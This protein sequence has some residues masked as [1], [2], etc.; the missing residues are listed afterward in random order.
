MSFDLAFWYEEVPSTVD[1][2]VRIY[3]RLVDGEPGVLSSSPQVEA[4]FED[5]V[6]IFGDL[7]EKTM[8]YSPWT[9][10]LEAGHGEG[11]LVCIAWSRCQEMTPLLVGLAHE[12][13]VTVFDPQDRNVWSPPR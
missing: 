6:A 9:A 2:A 7:D 11:V 3:L 1:Q 5:L 4:F 10:P 13:D 12:H 8:D